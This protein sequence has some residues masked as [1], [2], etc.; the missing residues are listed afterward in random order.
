[1]WELVKFVLFFGVL[2]CIGAVVYDKKVKPVPFV[3]SA[4]TFLSGLPRFVLS[5]FKGPAK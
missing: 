5:K 4:L 1:M 2:T 3:E